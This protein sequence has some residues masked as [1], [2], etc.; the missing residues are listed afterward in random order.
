MQFST[1]VRNPVQS[2][3]SVGLISAHL[4]SLTAPTPNTTVYGVKAIDVSRAAAEVVRQ[5]RHEVVGAAAINV[6][7]APLMDK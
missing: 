4:R 6:P 5:P 2:V 7:S 3:P 1:V